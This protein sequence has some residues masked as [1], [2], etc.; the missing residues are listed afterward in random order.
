MFAS[1]FLIHNVQASSCSFFTLVSPAEKGGGRGMGRCLL[2]GSY[3]SPFSVDNR[4]GFRKT[5]AYR[6]NPLIYCSSIR[7]IRM[8][9]TDTCRLWRSWS[10]VRSLELYRGRPTRLIVRF[11]GIGDI[12]FFH[13]VSFVV[14]NLH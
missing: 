11:H 13:I 10:H 14:V 5:M 9:V 6:Q 8:N 7:N 3:S 2:G 12:P 4:E 1:I